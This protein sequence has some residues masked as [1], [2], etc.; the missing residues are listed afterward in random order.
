MAAIKNKKI[1]DRVTLQLRAELFN[2]TNHPNFA[3]PAS[4]VGSRGVGQI[5]GTLGSNA[6]GGPTSYGTTQPRTMQF[7]V[8]TTF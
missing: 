2:I 8:K 7:G 4:Y 6:Y 3:A 1:G 5:G